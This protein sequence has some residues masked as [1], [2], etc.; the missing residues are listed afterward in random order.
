MCKKDMEQ[1]VPGYTVKSVFG[2]GNLYTS[3]NEVDGR[4]FR[5]FLKLGKA[6]ACESCLL[7]SVARLVTI[8]LQDTSVPLERICKTLSGIQC[9][10]GSIA[11]KSCVDSLAQM[12][13]KHIGD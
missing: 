9:E 13:K 5:V 11:G 2:C 10:K 12:L 1:Q 6:G 3:V 7:E 8:M 4:P